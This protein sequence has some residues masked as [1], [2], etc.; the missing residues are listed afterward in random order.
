M[1]WFFDFIYQMLIGMYT[2]Y[3]MNLH[4]Y[5]LWKK[6]DSVFEVLEKRFPSFYRRNE[7]NIKWIYNGEFIFII[8]FCTPLP[9]LFV[10]LFYM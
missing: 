5:F 6:R 1:D 4:Y 10:F 9:F 7:H 8:S 2:I 3:V